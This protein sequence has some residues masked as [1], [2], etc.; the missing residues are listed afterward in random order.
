MDASVAYQ[1][2]LLASEYHYFL[3]NKKK[4]KKKIHIKQKNVWHSPATSLL[5]L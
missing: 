1:H 4:N 2:V 3:E 5:P